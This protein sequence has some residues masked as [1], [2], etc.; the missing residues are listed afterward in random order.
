MIDKEEP[1]E[2]D[3]RG[4]PI[5]S[6][7]TVAH[8]AQQEEVEEKL[9]LHFKGF[10]RIVPET[11]YHYP[12]LQGLWLNNNA[13]VKI[14]GLERCTR[15]VSLFLNNNFISKIEGLEELKFLETLNLAHNK[16]ENIE[17]LEELHRLNSLNLSKNFILHSGA[18]SGLKDCPNLF[19]LDLSHNEI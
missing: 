15:L 7:K 3:Q 18:L 13:L 19:T 4:N 8:F 2:L 5:M 10:T 1:I 11:V 9:L 17:G 16:I 14:E 12:F 6:I